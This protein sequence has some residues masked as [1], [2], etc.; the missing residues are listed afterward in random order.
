M[1]DNKNMRKKV[2]KLI[3]N[4]KFKDF[5]ELRI[6]VKSKLDMGN[7]PYTIEEF[8]LNQ[9]IDE[10]YGAGFIEKVSYL[11]ISKTGK[12][13]LSNDDKKVE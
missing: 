2:L 10:C 13:L 1:N 12:Q 4:K 8:N 3:G 9:A 6:F 11:R 5:I 7:D